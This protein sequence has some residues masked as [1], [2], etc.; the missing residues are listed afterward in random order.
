MNSNKKRFFYS[1]FLTNNCDEFENYIIEIKLDK[2]II[3]KEYFSLTKLISWP[4]LEFQKAN[5]LN[6]TCD[7][8]IFLENSKRYQE[9][10]DYL[11]PRYH[12]DI[13]QT[14]FNDFKNFLKQIKLKAGRRF[15]VLANYY[16]DRNNIIN[17]I[18]FV[19]YLTD[20]DT[21]YKNTS[22]RQIKSNYNRKLKF[23]D[24]I[25][26]QNKDTFTTTQDLILVYYLELAKLWQLNHFLNYYLNKIPTYIRELYP[27][28]KDL[29]TETLSDIDLEETKQ[30]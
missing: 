7:L 29:E 9:R 27:M 20:T 12:Y 13:I 19:E 6:Q 8:C 24:N 16:N 5:F 25:F 28:I 30:K 4:I 15:K 26:A 3:Y 11:D 22:I 23:I 17:D 2:P 21:R 18:G 10:V 1:L 14:T